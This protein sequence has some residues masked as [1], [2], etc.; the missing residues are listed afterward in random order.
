MKK[1][2]TLGASS[3]RTSINKQFASWAA[4]HL[5][6]VEVDLADLNDYALPLFSVD[7][8]SSEGIPQGAQN[9]LA[10]IQASDALILSLAEHNGSYTAVFKNLLDWTSRAGKDLWSGKRML[11][12]STSPGGRG[13]SSVLAAANASFPHLGAKIAGSFALPSFYENFNPSKGITTPSLK[14]EFDTQLAIYQS[15]L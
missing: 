5:D 8:E 15:S 13:G 10:R 4:S 2:L 6:R 1:I 9:F 14:R 7:R 3:S 12:L 11:L